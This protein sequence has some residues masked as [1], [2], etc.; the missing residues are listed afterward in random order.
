MYEFCFGSQ[1]FYQAIFFDN[2]EIILSPDEWLV[3]YSNKAK[4]R[5]T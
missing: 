5:A 4:E 1:I 2:T 3:T